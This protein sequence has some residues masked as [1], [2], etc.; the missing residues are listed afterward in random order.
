MTGKISYSSDQWSK[1]VSHAASDNE[2]VTPAKGSEV[3]KTTSRNFKALYDEEA[4]LG[5]LLKQY[6]VYAMND[7]T[8]MLSVGQK[9]QTNDEQDAQ[10]ISRAS[11]RR[12]K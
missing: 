6:T 5:Q 1:V 7:T 9:I 11:V 2:A 3:A 8:K 4:V 12:I 10:A